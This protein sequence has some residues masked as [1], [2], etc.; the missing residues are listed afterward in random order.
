MRELFP[1]ISNL[2]EI[3]QPFDGWKKIESIFCL[4]YR[5]IRWTC[6]QRHAH[7][8]KA[9]Y[10]WFVLHCRMPLKMCKTGSLYTH[11]HTHQSHPTSK[12]LEWIFFCFVLFSSSFLSE[13]FIQMEWT[14]EIYKATH[15]QLRFPLHK[16]WKRI[17]I[18][19]VLILFFLFIHLKAFCCCSCEI[20]QINRHCSYG[21]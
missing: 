1:S 17:K 16:F 14:Y 5:L 19:L 20:T 13:Q 10:R 7:I 8:C 9:I 6:R 21:H 15:Q 4:I 12:T 2:F 11:T 3:S 18:C